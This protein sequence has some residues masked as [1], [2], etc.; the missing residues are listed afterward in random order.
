MNHL[1]GLG[2][3]FHPVEDLRPAVFIANGK[4]FLSTQSSRQTSEISD[5]DPR[6]CSFD[7]FA[8]CFSNDAFPRPRIQPAANQGITS[9]AGV[10]LIPLSILD[11][12]FASDFLSLFQMFGSANSQYV[13]LHRALRSLEI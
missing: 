10:C 5:I 3:K 1:T 11:R 13:R 7:A 4:L 6:T 12:T 2:K 8:S 9:Q